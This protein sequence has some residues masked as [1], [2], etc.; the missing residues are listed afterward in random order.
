[1][2]LDSVLWLENFLLTQVCVSPASLLPGNLPAPPLHLRRTSAAPPLQ[3]EG[4]ALV[5]VSHDREFL[6]RVTT[7]IVETEQG[8]AHSYA[9]IASRRG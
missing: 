1:M 9:E 6:D 2:D 7:K 4:L 3:T 8:V 5:L